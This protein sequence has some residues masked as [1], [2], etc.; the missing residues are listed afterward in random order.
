MATIVTFI[1]DDIT[2]S[3]LL[4]ADCALRIRVRRSEIG[5]VMLI[6]RPLPTR[7][8]HSRKRALEG[9][10]PEADPAQLELAEVAPRPSAPLAAAARAHRELRL[11]LR[12]GDPCRRGHVLSS[13]ISSCGTACRAR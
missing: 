6:A 7:L 3:V 4:R 8:G 10:V 5:S 12:L 9:E 1:F 13:R 2:S 11:A